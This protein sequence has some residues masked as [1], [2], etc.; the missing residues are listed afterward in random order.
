MKETE[1]HRAVCNYSVRQ[2]HIFNFAFLRKQSG[3]KGN[4]SLLEQL[5]TNACKNSYQVGVQVKGSGEVTSIILLSRTAVDY[6]K[7]HALL[8]SMQITRTNITGNRA[9]HGETL[10]HAILVHGCHKIIYFKD[11]FFRIIQ[12]KL[13]VF[14][15]LFAIYIH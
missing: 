6:K 13:K 2:P 3:S 15:Y 8:N 1:V 14:I 7:P 5:R 10:H 11:V 4:Q 12:C 9:S